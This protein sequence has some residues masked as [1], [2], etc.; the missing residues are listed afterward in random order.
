MAHL[1]LISH[2]CYLFEAAF[3]WELT[4][5]TIRL[6]LGCLQGGIPAGNATLEGAW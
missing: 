6:T 4:S 2:R 1:K 3:V 5:E